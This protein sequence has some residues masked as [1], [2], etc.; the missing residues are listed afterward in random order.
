M[1]KTILLAALLAPGIALASTVVPI[2]PK[3][4]EGLRVLGF[5]EDIQVVRWDVPD[6]EPMY[7]ATLPDGSVSFFREGEEQCLDKLMGPVS[8][9]Q[10]SYEEL[11]ED[12]IDWTVAEVSPFD[13]IAPPTRINAFVPN[14]PNPG[15]PWLP[16]CSGN[17]INPTDPVLPPVP[18]SSPVVYLLSALLLLFA[19]TRAFRK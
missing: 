5:K 18:L 11:T 10:P 6:D 15:W 7:A 3:I 17:P 13:V 14:D 19:A 16:C 12:Q 8:C 4:A 1:K 9:V 2:T